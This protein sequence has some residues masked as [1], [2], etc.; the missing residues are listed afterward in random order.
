MANSEIKYTKDGKIKDFSVPDAHHLYVTARRSSNDQV[1]RKEAIALISPVEI[2]ALKLR[3]DPEDGLIYGQKW[4]INDDVIKALLENGDCVHRIPGFAMY[5]EY[6][7][8]PMRN[9]DQL[10]HKG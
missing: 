3:K 5:F 7:L 9:K 1:I 2:H 6:K 8:V 10:K 4:A